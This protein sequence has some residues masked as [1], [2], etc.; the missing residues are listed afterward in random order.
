[1]NKCKIIFTD[2]PAEKTVHTYWF[3]PDI[4]KEEL[5]WEITEL[6]K[7]YDL[8]DVDYTN[9]ISKGEMDM[10]EY[11]INDTKMLK[12][13]KSYKVDGSGRVIIPTHLRGRFGVDVGDMVD[14]YTACVDGKWV[15]CVTKSEKPEA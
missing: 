12:E 3:P 14:F 9:F 7:Y 11:T 5:L 1:M 4:S 13:D 10:M 2:S 8:V 15:L 6:K